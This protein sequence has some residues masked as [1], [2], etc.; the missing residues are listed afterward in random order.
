MTNLGRFLAD[1]KHPWKK[2]VHQFSG[3]P[4]IT[5]T[6]FMLEFFSKYACSEADIDAVLQMIHSVSVPGNKLPKNHKEICKIT[7]EL[8]VHHQKHMICPCGFFTFKKEQICPACSRT[9]S[10]AQRYYTIPIIPRLQQMFETPSLA[11]LLQENQGGDS[12]VM[13]DI[14]STPSWR[15]FQQEMGGE[16]TV[17]I[18]YCSDGFNPYHHQATSRN[19]S[20]WAQSGIILNLPV[21]IR[22]QMKYAML[23]GL[24]CGPSTP[25]N[26][27]SFN[28]IIVEEL[29]LLKDGVMAYDG[30]RK[31]LTLMKGGLM[32][33]VCDVPGAAKE[34]HRVQHNALKACPHCKV[35][36]EHSCILEKVIFL[37]SRKFL[38][39]DDLLRRDTSFPSGN[40]EKDVVFPR[41]DKE[42]M[43]AAR[44][45]DSMKVQQLFG[46]G[47]AVQSLTTGF[48]KDTGR[49]G[50]H[51]WFRLGLD[52][53]QRHAPVEPMHA[54]KVVAEHLVRLLNGTEDGAKVRAEERSR[55]RF[56]D[57]C[58]DSVYRMHSKKAPP[59]ASIST[60]VQEQVPEMQ[61]H[62]P[63]KR[64][65]SSKPVLPP[66]PFTLTKEEKE[67]ADMRLKNVKVP[68][69]FGD[70]PAT[71]FSKTTGMK[72]HT[73]MKIFTSGILRYILRD[74]LGTT[75]RQT[76]F[77]FLSALECLYSREIEVAG[78]DQMEAQWHRVLA[79]MER[80]FPCA[81]K[82]TVMHLMHHLPRYIR[83]FGPV[84]NFWMFPFERMNSTFSKAIAGARYPELAAIKHM[85]IQWMLTI[86]RAA[87][88]L[89]DVRNIHNPESSLAGGRSRSH[90]LTDEE[91]GHLYDMFEEMGITWGT[92]RCITM[93]Q[94]AKRFVSK[95]GSMVTYRGSF[96]DCS[97]ATNCSIVSCSTNAGKTVVGHAMFFFNHINNLGQQ[98]IIAS[99][100]WVGFAREDKPS[101][102][103]QVLE[104]EGPVHRCFVPLDS[105]SSPLVHAWED[106]VLWIPSL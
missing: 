16:S 18:S 102:C 106:S 67:K 3:V 99:V 32:M 17:A 36:G 6:A 47:K 45:L 8:I 40:I 78:L 23:F 81:L 80:D 22:T 64:T 79:L 21:Q 25:A 70:L 28:R 101:K 43:L 10:D 74:A 9:N 15:D 27:N 93:H 97:T 83:M 96:L 33:L 54:I 44:C 94:H 5:Y 2:P 29:L 34:Q 69:D 26:L 20:I 24:I 55:G 77:E 48:T 104:E 68:V 105:L 95:E 103:L 61:S 37:G 72:S 63:G 87:G 53:S 86:L 66:A 65:R 73:W 42:E 4:I 51:Q 1:E 7:D 88:Y 12:L 50:S 52:L 98:N 46:N 56:I 100:D 49:H 31:K 71:L 57:Y 58:P 76:F 92:N 35:E 89:G 91:Y 13:N 90:T 60:D 62:G 41:V 84:S 82:G 11:K 30:L 14:H 85:E 75:Q 59:T 38:P 19:Y 39:P